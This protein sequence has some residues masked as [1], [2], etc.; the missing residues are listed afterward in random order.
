MSADFSLEKIEGIGKKRLES[1]KRLGIQ[2]PAEVLTYFPRDYKDRSRFSQIS[3]CFMNNLDE[4]VVR[5]TVLGHEYISPHSKN[6]IL[7]IRVT[8]GTVNASLVCFNRY[9]L[10]DTFI[11]GQEYILAG[12]FEF[13]YNEFQ[14][15]DFEILNPEEE[16]YNSGRIIPIYP[17]TEGITNKLMR[18]IVFECLTRCIDFKKESLPDYLIKKYGLV[19]RGFSLLN[20]HFPESMEACA[21]ACERL[22]YYEFFEFQFTLAL[23]KHYYHQAVKQRKMVVSDKLAQVEELL[24]YNL[25]DD[26]KTALKEILNDITGTNQMNRL[27]LGDVG[28]GKTVVGLL[29]AIPVIESGYQAALMA[30]TEILAAQHYQTVKTIFQSCNYECALLT[31]ALSPKE[32]K[33]ILEGLAEGRIQLVIG[34]H[35]LFQQSVNFKSLGYVMID[36]QQR[37]GVMQ[38]LELVKKGDNPDILHLSATPIPRTLSLSLYGDLDISII[39][40]KPAGRKKV[41]TSVIKEN[42]LSFAYDKIKTEIDSG[43]RAYIIYPLV[44]DSDKIELKAASVMYKKIKNEILAGISCGIV[45]GTMNSDDK[46]KVMN[47]F[48]TGKISVLVSTTVVEVGVDVPE[49]TVMLIEHAERYGLSTL[50]QL[51][52]RIGRG[53]EPAYCYL[54]APGDS[55]ESSARRLKIMEETDDG[56]IIA[57][58]DLMIRGPGEFLG[59]RQHGSL[60]F[61]LASLSQDKELLYA[62]REDAFSIIQKDPEMKNAENS[63]LK[64]TIYKKFISQNRDLLGS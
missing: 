15:S 61:K 50:H 8:D 27:L 35:A 54:V 32:R 14:S 26:Q 17:L 11:Q 5:V 25:T 30:P 19:S 39:R 52:G 7:K 12:K 36:E 28:S 41:S 53:G 63:I 46:D 37:F 44:E 58:E 31:G 62:A 23:K 1:L 59:V 18:K 34:T 33:D 10:K 16:P 38:R 20:I 48:K 21:R 24:P 42:Q 29:S 2:T 49:A 45:Y 64:N 47:D 56:F 43:H 3:D 51:R 9:F 40:E 4:I 22:K 60:P 6:R 55:T 13:K 57:E